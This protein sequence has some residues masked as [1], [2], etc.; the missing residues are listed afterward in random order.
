[1]IRLA[2]TIVDQEAGLGAFLASMRPRALRVA[3]LEVR[4]P[5][6]AADLVQDAMMRLV[7][8]YGQ[9]P[10]EEWIPLFY[11][12]L[13]NRIIDWRRR[14][15]VE[16]I[17]DFFGIGDEDSDQSAHYADPRAG[18]ERLFADQELGQRIGAAVAALPTRQREAFLLR[19]WEG[20]SVAEA[21]RAMGVSDGSVKTHHF[22]A[23]ARLREL[24][25]EENPKED[26]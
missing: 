10:Q 6:L 24:L 21:G 19:E 8:R 25:G 11:R 5:T 2:Q 4:D 17:V 15:R 20:L 1:M 23:L 22:R 13:R 12:I 26:R 18:P 7:Q 3:W 14:R 9:R 16:G